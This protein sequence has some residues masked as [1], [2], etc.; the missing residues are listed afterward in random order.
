MFGLKSSFETGPQMSFGAGFAHQ[1]DGPEMKVQSWG[2][3]LGGA[4]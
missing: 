4:P 1:E 2:F 3:F